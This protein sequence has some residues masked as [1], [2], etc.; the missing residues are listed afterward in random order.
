MS[1]TFVNDSLCTTLCL[2]WEPEVKATFSLQRMV[3]VHTFY[4]V[5]AML[6][7]WNTLILAEKLWII[8]VDIDIPSIQ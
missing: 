8:S 7:Y 3:A 5:L 4:L 1:W 2:Q 6:E